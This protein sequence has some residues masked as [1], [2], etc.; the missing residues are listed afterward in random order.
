LMVV[1]KNG[2]VQYQHYGNGMQDIPANKVV[3][4]VLDAFNQTL[5]R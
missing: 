1:D 2:I 4:D 5:E 3:F